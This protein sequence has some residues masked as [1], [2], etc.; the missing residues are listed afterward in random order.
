MSIVFLFFLTDTEVKA[1]Y[2]IAP[3]FRTF[4]WRGIGKISLFN[5]GGNI[6]TH[7]SSKLIV[8]TFLRLDVTNWFAGIENGAFEVQIDKL[9]DFSCEVEFSIREPDDSKKYID[10]VFKVVIM[11]YIRLIYR[12]TVPK[13]KCFECDNICLVWERSTH[14]LC[15]RFRWIGLR[16]SWFIRWEY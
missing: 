5:K 11:I 13:K 7:K 10:L 16:V 8:Q 2:Q 4:Y 3:T 9:G 12:N 15:W 14:L 1:M 6:C